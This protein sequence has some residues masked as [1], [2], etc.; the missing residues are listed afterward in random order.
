MMAQTATSDAMTYSLPNRDQ[1]LI[2][3]CLEGDRRAQKSLYLR[4][5]DAMY[6]LAYR[7]VNNTDLA[8]DALQDAFLEIFRDLWNYRGESTLGAWMKTIVIRC[9]YRTIQ[10]EDRYSELPDSLEDVDLN[11][12]HFT[13]QALDRE[14][15]A[16]PDRSRTVFTLYE[17]EGYKHPEI[18]EMLGITAST[19]RTQLLYAKKLL[20]KKL[21]NEIK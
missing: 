3:A 16:L 5:A 21:Q 4:Y 14:I 8:H 12:E 1:E 10:K 15:M 20:Q 6:T 9:S 17:I 11:Y 18:A 7:I 2:I 19:S 13:S